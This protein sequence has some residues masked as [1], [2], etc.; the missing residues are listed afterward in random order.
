M[1]DDRRRFIQEETGIIMYGRLLS[2]ASSS[3][4]TKVGSLNLTTYD[5]IL[6]FHKMVPISIYEPII[7]YGGDIGHS[8]WA[9][10]YNCAL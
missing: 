4:L 10:T 6:L 7:P 5:I 1:K 9:S 8:H 2:L 3:S